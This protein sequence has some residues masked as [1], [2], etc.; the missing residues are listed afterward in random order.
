MSLV[1]GSLAD[2]SS[3]ALSNAL[4]NCHIASISRLKLYMYIHYTIAQAGL[5]RL[6]W[7]R[8]AGQAGLGLTVNI[9][10]TYSQHTVNT[11]ST[12]QSTCPPLLNFLKGN[13]HMWVTKQIITLNYI[14]L[15]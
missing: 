2:L 11:Q 10:S 15:M 13:A 6:D 4:A 12:P 9:Q 7:A 3:R 8:C 5:G 1:I 14:N